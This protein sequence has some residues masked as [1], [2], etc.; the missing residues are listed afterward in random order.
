MALYDL[1]HVPLLCVSLYIKTGYFVDCS[2]YWLVNSSAHQGRLKFELFV[3]F[4]LFSNLLLTYFPV[5]AVTCSLMSVWSHFWLI[6]TISNLVAAINSLLL[7]LFCQSLRPIDFIVILNS[8]GLQIS[9]LREL[10]CC[11]LMMNIVPWPS[12]H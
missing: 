2:S 8:F 9:C 6:F 5:F 1:M 3:H 11:T 10:S 7:F 4:E 12:W